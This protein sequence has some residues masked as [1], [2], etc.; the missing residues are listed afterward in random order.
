MEKIL[1][2]GTYNR[3]VDNM[4]H[5]IEED[6]AG[7]VP[8]I[9]TFVGEPTFHSL[10]WERVLAWILQTMLY[11]WKKAGTSAGQWC[12]SNLQ[13]LKFEVRMHTTWSHGHRQ[14]M[15]NQAPKNESNLI[16]RV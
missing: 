2:L 13:L 11:Q 14:L 12:L 8:R 5:I 16:C 7:L 9:H 15:L 3:P 6:L 10:L 4:A 1:Q